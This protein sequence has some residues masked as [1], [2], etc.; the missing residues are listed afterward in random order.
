MLFWTKMPWGDRPERRPTIKRRR[1]MICEECGEEYD[2]D[3]PCA[4]CRGGE[5]EI[6]ESEDG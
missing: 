6:E 5:D 4:C 1:E 3:N 2:Y